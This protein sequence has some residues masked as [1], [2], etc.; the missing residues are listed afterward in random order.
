M[1]STDGDI[2]SWAGGNADS[3]GSSNGQGVNIGGTDAN[4]LNGFGTFEGLIGAVR[5]HHRMLHGDEIRASFEANAPIPE[6]LTLATLTMAGAGLGAYVR[7]RRR[8]RA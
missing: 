3:L 8:Q 4:D 7:R 6:P 5:M 1:D 2:V